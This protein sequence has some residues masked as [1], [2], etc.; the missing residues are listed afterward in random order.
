MRCQKLILLVFVV[1][2][3]NSYADGC[4]WQ[5]V[6]IK[7]SPKEAMH[8]QASNYKGKINYSAKIGKY[9]V[10]WVVFNDPGEELIFSNPSKK[11][12]CKVNTGGII[13]LKYTFYNSSSKVFAV[14]T[15]SGST[16]HIEFYNVRT[17]KLLNVVDI[18]VDETVTSKKIV[19]KGYCECKDRCK[20]VVSLC[21]SATVYTLDKKCLPH[22]DLD[23]SKQYTKK[24]FGVYFK[25]KQSINLPMTNMAEVVIEK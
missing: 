10:D 22:K 20:G 18:S 14:T 21:Y 24:R 2:A 8:V 9:V 16:R 23:L 12:Q 6:N 7:I 5:A 13:T 11:K 1:Y 17:C 25:G 19:N 3:F 15:Y 4:Q